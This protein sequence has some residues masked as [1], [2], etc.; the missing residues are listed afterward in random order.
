MGEIMSLEK[1]MKRAII[2][3]LIA[4]MI[5]LVL[6]MFV[7]SQ[8]DAKEPIEPEPPVDTENSYVT[9]DKRI[10]VEP[11]QPIPSFSPTHSSTTVP[12]QDAS[13]TVVP[14]LPT[15]ENPLPSTSP[16]ILPIPTSVKIR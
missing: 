12:T 2:G 6:L 14:S 10:V 3:F 7:A 13:E 4:M 5:V 9:D 1:I 11:S 16:P 15:T 8:D